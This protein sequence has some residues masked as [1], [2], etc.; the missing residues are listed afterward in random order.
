MMLMAVAA[1]ASC[2]KQPVAIEEPEAGNGTYVYTIKASV[3][4]TKSDY[5]AN[6]H[7]TWSSGDA[8]SGLTAKSPCEIEGLSEDGAYSV[9]KEWQVG[10][11]S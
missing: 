3:P 9:H 10:Y 5:D 1:I 7:F 2:E 11:T 4:E 8:I 6:G